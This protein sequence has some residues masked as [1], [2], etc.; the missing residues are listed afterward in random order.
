M[1]NK[2]VTFI[3]GVTGVFNNRPPKPRYSCF[4]MLR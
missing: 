4:G 3:T 2:M 1:L